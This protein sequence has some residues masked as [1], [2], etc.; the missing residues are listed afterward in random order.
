MTYCRLPEIEFHREIYLPGLLQCMYKYMNVHIQFFVLAETAV[1][2][3]SFP[4][5]IVHAF[6]SHK[7]SISNISTKSNVLQSCV[8]RCMYSLSLLATCILF[9]TPENVSQ[10]V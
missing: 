3:F 8:S 4:L 1:K 5:G 10:N 7:E 9:L 6:R 2:I